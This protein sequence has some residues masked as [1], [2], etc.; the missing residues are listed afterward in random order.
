[1]HQI[2]SSTDHG[3]KT[4]PSTLS[5]EFTHAHPFNI[6]ILYTDLTRPVALPFDPIKYVP[7]MQNDFVKHL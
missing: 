2:Y 7:P 3:D 6:E 4:Q 1:M 5:V